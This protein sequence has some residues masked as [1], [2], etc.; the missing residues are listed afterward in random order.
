MNNRDFQIKATYNNIPWRGIAGM[1]DI[2]AHKYQTLKMGDV[3][4]TLEN[5]IPILKVELTQI[6]NND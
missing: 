5:E 1:R 3:W 6:I 4:F 2:T